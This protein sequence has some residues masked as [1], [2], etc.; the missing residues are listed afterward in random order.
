MTT[1]TATGATVTVVTYS[2]AVLVVPELRSRVAGGVLTVRTVSLKTGLE[3]ELD[4][5]L[6]RN[7]EIHTHLRM[8][9]LGLRVWDLGFG[10]WVS[11]FR[12]WGCCLGLRV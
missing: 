11:G 2:Q 1:A 4:H 5:A 3:G 7:H 12:V 10:V 6:H 9:C 8:Y